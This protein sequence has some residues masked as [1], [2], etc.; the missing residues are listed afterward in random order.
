MIENVFV[1]SH[2]LG[3]LDAELF[4]LLIPAPLVN[5]SLREAS[6]QRNRQKGL[7]GPVRVA[8]EVRGE[9]VQ[10]EGRLSLALSDDSFIEAAFLVI[11]VAA[12]LGVG[13]I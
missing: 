7:L 9:L 13:R 12:A 3:L 1:L 11:D 5:L 6:F 2:A 4:A 8:V 10:L